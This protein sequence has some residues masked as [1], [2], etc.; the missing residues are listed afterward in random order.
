VVAETRAEGVP[1]LFGLALFVLAP[2]LVFRG[3]A[4][5]AELLAEGALPPDSAPVLVLTRAVTVAASTTPKIAARTTVKRVP[6]RLGRIR[7]RKIELRARRRRDLNSDPLF[8]KTVL[9]AL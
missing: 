9:R 7:R 4:V 5:V 6:R 1:L 3:E 2:V 8:T